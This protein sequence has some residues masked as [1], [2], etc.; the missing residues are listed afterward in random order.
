L[1]GTSKYI[2]FNMT[3]LTFKDLINMGSIRLELDS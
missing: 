2:E 3:Y 1:N